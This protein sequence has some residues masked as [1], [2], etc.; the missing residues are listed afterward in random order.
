MALSERFRGRSVADALSLRAAEAPNHPFVVLGDR[1]LT[2]GQVEAQAEA[3]H[4]ELLEL[5]YKHAR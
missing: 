3:M 1:R 5:M 4:E 2:Y